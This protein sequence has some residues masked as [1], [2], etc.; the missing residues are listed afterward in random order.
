MTTPLLHQLFSPHLA[1]G[2]PAAPHL[3][4]HPHFI[5]KD[6]FQIDQS[7]EE[8]HKSDKSGESDAVRVKPIMAEKQEH[9]RA[10]GKQKQKKRRKE[11][12][13]YGVDADVFPIHL[14]PVTGMRL[15]PVRSQKRKPFLFR[16]SLSGM[17]VF[18]S[19]L[20]QNVPASTFALL[21]VIQ[22]P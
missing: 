4:N 1:V 21:S 5:K 16:I 11:K 15:K 18:P 8:E 17:N 6:S 13:G 2:H 22:I 14:F 7:D 9:P 19:L 10:E 20:P 3:R 12:P